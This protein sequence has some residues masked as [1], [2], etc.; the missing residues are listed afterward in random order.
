LAEF[1]ET[2]GAIVLPRFKVEYGAT[3]KADARRDFQSPSWQLIRS[4]KATS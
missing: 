2:D 1:R 3:L 4:R